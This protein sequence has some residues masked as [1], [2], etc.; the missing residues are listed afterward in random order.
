MPAA[1]ISAIALVAEIAKLR[2]ELELAD[3]VE[4]LCLL[5]QVPTGAVEKS[6]RCKMLFERDGPHGRLPPWASP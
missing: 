3:I 2:D 4:F 5:L 1:S 6:R